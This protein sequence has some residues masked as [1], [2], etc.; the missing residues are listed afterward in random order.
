[1]D[2]NKTQLNNAAPRLSYSAPQL[3]AYGAVRDLTTAGSMLPLE[4][5]KMT[6][7]AKRF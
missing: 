2:N 6:A 5:V 7:K 4:G 1:M 3:V